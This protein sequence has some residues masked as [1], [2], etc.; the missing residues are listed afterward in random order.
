VSALVNRKV[1]AVSSGLGRTAARRKSVEDVPNEDQDGNEKRARKTGRG[2]TEL[3]PNENL[4]KDAGEADGDAEIPGRKRKN[5]TQVLRMGFNFS[6]SNSRS[7]D[8]WEAVT[9]R[10]RFSTVFAG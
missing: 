8:S 5:D 2:D 6:S 10:S 3:P 4:R 9:G 1:R 7:V